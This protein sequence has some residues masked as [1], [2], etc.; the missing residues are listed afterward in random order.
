MLGFRTE[1]WAYGTETSWTRVGIHNARHPVGLNRALVQEKD[2]FN[3]QTCRKGVA[4]EH[5]RRAVRDPLHLFLH[6][7]NQSGEIVGQHTR[8][9]PWR[10]FAQGIPSITGTICQLSRSVA[11]RAG[12]AI[13]IRGLV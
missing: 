5:Y 11:G 13:R 9:T 3:H 1:Y 4:P 7:W 2:F 8:Y 6:R 10:S 12:K